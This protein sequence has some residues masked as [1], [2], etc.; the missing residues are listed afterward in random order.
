MRLWPGMTCYFKPKIGKPLQCVIQYEYGPTAGKTLVRIGTDPFDT[1]VF[2]NQ[3]IERSA[4]TTEVTEP[5]TTEAAPRKRGR[6][7]KNPVEATVTPIETARKKRKPV[8]EVAEPVKRPRGR[9]RKNPVEDVKPVADET[10][11]A[12]RTRAKATPEPIAV[13][14]GPGRPKKVAAE[15]VAEAP[16]R[17]GRPP[18]NA[19]GTSVTPA[20]KVATKTP[21]TR[22]PKPVEATA[23][24]NPFRKGS[25]SYM[26][27]QALMKGGTRRAM[28][29]RLAKS[30]QVTPWSK[31]I[32]AADQIAEI[33]TRLGLC[34]HQLKT[35][36]GWTVER[37]GRGIDGKIR[38]KP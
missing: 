36:F 12:R 9:P 5:D 31:E 17:R 24:E 11:K 38:V 7:R 3:L 37:N 22:G 16:K 18:K 29:T 26:Y 6:P 20:K 34:A 28:A 19:A 13:K 27:C 2:T 23:T 35:K 1:H 21:A 14:R 15:P 8:A 30:I 10:P 4:M 32:T 33:D 25:N